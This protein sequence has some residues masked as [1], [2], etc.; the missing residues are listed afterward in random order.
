MYNAA[1]SVGDPLHDDFRNFVFVCMKALGKDVAL[2][3][4]DVAE[5]LQYGPDRRMVS[6]LRGFGK[7]WLTAILAVWFLYRD[8]NTTI[9]CVSGTQNRATEFIGLCRQLLEVMPILHHLRPREGDRDG[10]YRFDC[11]ART[12]ANKD[13][14]VCAYGIG[15]MMMGAHA[16]VI[17]ADDVESPH[18]SETVEAREKLYNACL[19]F[20][21]ILNPGGQIVYLGTPQNRESIYN[22]LSENY[23][24]RRWPARYPDPANPKA[25]KNLAPKLLDDLMSG[26]AQPRDPTY[27]E[28]FPEEVLID[29]EAIMGPTVFTLQ[30]M[31]DTSL[32]DADRYPLRPSDFI[33][34]PVNGTMAPARV[35]WGTNPIQ[36]ISVPT[37]DPLNGP[38]FYSKDDYQPYAMTLMFIDPAGQG[39]DETAWAIIKFL[40][41]TIFVAE[42]MG[43]RGGP[44]EENLLKIASA[45]QRHG[46]QKI[47]VEQNFGDG[48]FEQLLKPFISRLPRPAA[49]ESK[50]SGNKQK[51]L[52]II[53]TLEPLMKMHRV[54]IDPEVGRDQLL[55]RQVADITR[56]R[57]SLPH[58][59]RIEALAGACSLVQPLVSIDPET[60]LKQ[61][62][63]AES[64]QAAKDFMASVTG[65]SGN[66]I[67][68]MMPNAPVEPGLRR[69]SGSWFKP[70]RRSGGFI[71]R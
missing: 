26:R 38:I 71:R 33:V 10:A 24:L 8:P 41:G 37:G 32:A 70:G 50:R 69:V 34:M 4:Y 60:F 63:E 40:N 14:S 18:N 17:I 15:S 6:A 61:K 22:R 25:M 19:E 39:L 21:A 66:K 7:S 52:R 13:P 12:A 44:T 54:V 47:T 35:V 56:D 5:F 59:D 36:N 43:I 48:M 31:L 30:M 23:T 20:E 9:L 28:R 16:D 2:L 57:G 42:V 53:D 45:V 62:K 64:M 55:M 65:R 51:E 49:I 46:V 58:D 11:G 67:I 29:R 1:H 3:Q 27:P 68:G